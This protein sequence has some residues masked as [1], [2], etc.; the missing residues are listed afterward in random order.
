MAPLDRH[1]LVST[2]QVTARRSRRSP[3]RP[4]RPREM[5]DHRLWIRYCPNRRQSHIEI[6]NKSRTR[7]QRA[8]FKLVKIESSLASRPWSLT[9]SANGATT[10]CSR[11]KSQPSGVFVNSPKKCEGAVPS[12]VLSKCQLGRWRDMSLSPIVLDG[13]AGEW[14][15][16]LRNP[17]LDFDDV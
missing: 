11:R 10:P 4:L 17:R 13:I 9:I 5:A 14:P 12:Y 7:A 8:H 6:R 2:R 15:Q 16:C 1:T 3:R